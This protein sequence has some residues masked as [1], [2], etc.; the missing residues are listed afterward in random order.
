MRPYSLLLLLYNVL[1]TTSWTNILMI[2]DSN[3]RNLVISICD[4]YKGNG[5]NFGNEDFV[6]QNGVTSKSW[7]SKDHHFFYHGLNGFASFSK[8]TMKNWSDLKC[9]INSMNMTLFSLQIF[10][11]S[12]SPPYYLR[13][14]SNG[15]EN[16]GPYCD[17]KSRVAH[18]IDL[19]H[20]QLLDKKID[21]IMFQSIGWD[22]SYQPHIST[23][24]E[25]MIENYR[26]RINQLLELSPQSKIILRTQPVGEQ[27][28]QK[29]KIDQYNEKVVKKV[30][31]EYQHN[32][33]L[34]DLLLLNTNNWFNPTDH[35]H[36]T[37]DYLHR[38]FDIL[39]ITFDTI[40][41]S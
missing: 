10:G 13:L 21:Y 6:S 9:D 40:K 37:D 8:D 22:I 2:G 28:K 34:I 24:D 12:D 14:C 15:K 30:A 25:S 18:G 17:T 41:Q 19:I 23:I 7:C 38:F 27:Y 29:T 20:K 36:F 16:D 11:A 33:F 31:H 1:K 5:T 26:N 32:I 39:V 4:L 35:F 3:D